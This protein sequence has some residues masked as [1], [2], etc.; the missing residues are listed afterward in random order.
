MN[1][2][3]WRNNV[4]VWLNDN[5]RTVEWLAQKCGVER[6]TLQ[7]NLN[8]SK[9]IDADL[10]EKIDLIINPVTETGNDFSTVAY[11]TKILEEASKLNFDSFCSM[12][13][14]VFSAEEKKLALTRM[15]ILKTKINQYE[16]LLAA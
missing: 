2:E 12:A 15:Q 10:K 7:Y 11:A 1:L 3:Q 4:C 8:Y 13:D 6:T 14:G 5:H 16:R 9:K